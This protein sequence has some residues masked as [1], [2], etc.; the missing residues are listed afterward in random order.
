MPG[1][2][3]PH[4]EL[5]N[6]YGEPVRLGALRG[7]P[8]VLV[9]FPFAFS[10]VCTR[11][12]ADLQAARGLFD[13]HGARLLGISTDSRFTLRAYAETEALSFD[14]LSDF[15]PH[16]AAARAFGVF[17]EQT[18]QAGRSTF[19]LDADGIVSSVVSSGAGEPRSAADYAVAL[20]ALAGAA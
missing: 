9:F 3:A 2:P 15:W 1:E 12:L 16:G 7:A 10:R 11:E 17:D 18:G 4:A 5:V 20:A 19:F 14:L 8:A 13:S 6:Q